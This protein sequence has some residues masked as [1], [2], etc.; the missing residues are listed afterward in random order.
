ML[1]SRIFF[2]TCTLTNTIG[3]DLFGSTQSGQRRPPARIA[4]R[5]TFRAATLIPEEIRA[6]VAELEKKEQEERNMVVND[7]FADLFEELN[8]P[9]DLPKKNSYGEKNSSSDR[10]QTPDNSEQDLLDR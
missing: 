7:F 4:P 3:A 2:L 9:T 5:P 6:M 1:F 10:P 8:H